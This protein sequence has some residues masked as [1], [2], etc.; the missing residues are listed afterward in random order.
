MAR[1]TSFY[2]SAASS[3]TAEPSYLL[4]KLLQKL[5]AQSII[6]T[7]NWSGQIRVRK[8]PN[9]QDVSELGAKKAKTKIATSE[10]ID[11]ITREYSIV[12]GIHCF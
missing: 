5:F 4:V 10:I 9:T 8:D 12:R 3:Q 7:C 1:V 6:R 11:V 2:A